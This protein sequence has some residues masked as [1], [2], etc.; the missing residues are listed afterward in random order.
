[1]PEVRGADA[2]CV[3]CI[4]TLIHCWCVCVKFFIDNKSVHNVTSRICGDSIEVIYINLLLHV[5]ST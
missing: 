5:S 3:V 1:M 4:M 2:V